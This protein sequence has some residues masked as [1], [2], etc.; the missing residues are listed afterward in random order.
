M[1]VKLATSLVAF[2]AL[3]LAAGCGS[4]DPAAPTAEK[5]GQNG[6][7]GGTQAVNYPAGPYGHTKDTVLENKTFQGLV[8]PSAAS[9]VADEATTAKIQFADFY[10]PTKDPS[11]PLVLV[12]T[13]AARWC[14]PCKQEASVSMKHYATWHPKGVEF[15]VTVIEDASNPP[16]DATFTDLQL[17]TKAYKLEY[18]TVIDPGAKNMS[19]FFNKSAIPFNMIVDTTT[20]TIKYTVEGLLDMG[21][22][23]AGGKLIQKYLDEAAAQL[24]GS[25]IDPLRRLG[26]TLAATAACLSSRA[27]LAEPPSISITETSVVAV[28]TASRFNQPWQDRYAEW[29]NR[30]NIQTSQGRWTAALRIDS[31]VYGLKGDPNKLAA[32][33]TADPQ[34]RESLT[35]GYGV[36]LS[37]HYRNV[38]YPAKVFA[39]YAGKN[40]DVTFGDF[41]A[42]FGR[43]LALSMRK[44]DELGSDTTIRGAKVNLRTS[45]DHG[46]QASL[47]VLGGLTNP[48]RVDDPT[49]TTLTSRS[50]ALFPLAPTARATPYVTDPRPNFE[51]DAIV[52]VR[53]EAGTD[54]VTFGVHTVMLRRLD[55]NRSCAYGWAGDCD[56]QTSQTPLLT[57]TQAGSLAKGAR[58]I[59]IA[60]ASLSFPNIADHG[61]FYVEGAVQQLL[62]PAHAPGVDPSRDTERLSGGTALYLLATA[63]QGPVTFSFEGKRY[64]RYYPLAASATA[65][66]FAALQYNAPPTTQLIYQDSEFNS[67]NVCVLGG[68]GRVDVRATSS[69]LVYASVGRYRSYTEDF[70]TDACGTQ[71][72]AGR[73]RGRVAEDRH[74]AWDGYG[75]TEVN[76]EGGRSH[77]FFFGGAR[78]DEKGAPSPTEPELGTAYYREAWIRYDVVKRIT[79]PYS[80]QSTGSHRYRKWHDIVDNTTGLVKP[81]NEGETYLAF[82]WSPHL[83]L[84]VGHE[85]TSRASEKL[86]H[87]GSVFAQYRFTS[88]KVVRLFAGQTRENIRCISGVCRRFPAFSGAKVEAVLRF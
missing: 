62:A 31:A 71:M 68:R 13:A 15:L 57:G 36:Q 72:E 29:V 19:A 73:E 24:V 87:F 69:V 17:W 32:S 27:A 47:L 58:N 40:V 21:E 55:G 3:V 75:G 38:F 25:R 50:H 26:A 41:Y 11:K 9:F 33:E 80:I 12:M 2:T 61:T 51:P 77:L 54:F 79:G 82:I 56:P 64:E 23:A 67:F 45:F 28:H 46:G 76:F 6:A 10:N 83:T 44:V 74:D 86:L 59:N 63:Y 14:G 65:T 85:Y 52:G 49:G 70:G 20:M 18:P 34:Q 35:N 48:V 30:L 81:W 84:A 7:A 1:N 66:E 5:N 22:T 16:N 4:D 88:D 43:G 42:Q 37:T 60:G 8:N 53:Q 39:T 78:S